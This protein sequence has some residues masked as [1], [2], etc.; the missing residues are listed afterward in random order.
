MIGKRNHL[1]LLYIPLIALLLAWPIFG[2]DDPHAGHDH[3]D[4]GS[5]LHVTSAQR[6]STECEH[7]ILARDC[8]ECSPEVGVVHV[9]QEL[10]H[11][12][13][14]SP[15]LIAMAPCRPS[16][17]ETLMETYGHV[18]LDSSRASHI[19]PR[20]RGVITTVHTVLGADVEQ[21][22]PLFDIHSVEA[23]S[24]AADYL[25]ALALARLAQRELDRGKKLHKERVIS[26]KELLR[27]DINA[28]HAAI[29]RETT[30]RR[31]IIIGV[32]LEEL[33]TPKRSEQ[34]MQGFLTVRSPVKGRIIEKHAVIGEMVEPGKDVLLIANLS[35]VWVWAQ[36]YDS[37]AAAIRQ[38]MTDLPLD[39][40]VTV[41]ST[42][43]LRFHGMLDYISPIVDER[44]RTL[45]VRIVVA[46]SRGSGLLPG[47][48]CRAYLPIS[49]E[50][51]LSIDDTA[52]LR[53]EDEHFVFVPDKD[54][55]FV[56]RPISIGP[57]QNG[58]RAIT[59]GLEPGQLVITQGAFMLKSELF[60]SRMGAG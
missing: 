2:A 8:R 26:E 41:D 51:Q 32:S 11:S 5:P 35:K 37:D 49:R 54:G 20:V 47:M 17:F 28:E 57:L 42:P 4:L 12:D 30:R 23:G 38:R 7:G 50:I 22:T 36:V 58:Q 10:L 19:S 33:E 60:K 40:F 14:G 59:Q 46:N 13:D 3:G 21:G 55:Q 48:F 56:A 1:R 6:D 25:K 9:P 52:V 53:D 29:E 15:P 43:D 44:T 45:K 27:L 16:T 31:L 34:L 24:A 18:A 39:A